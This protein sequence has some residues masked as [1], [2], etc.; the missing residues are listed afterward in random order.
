GYRIFQGLMFAHSRAREI[1]SRFARLPSPN[2]QSPAE[3]SDERHVF[4]HKCRGLQ[5]PDYSFGSR[6]MNDVEGC[7][8]NVRE[9]LPGRGLQERV[10]SDTH[11]TGSIA[12]ES[13]HHRN[14]T[15]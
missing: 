6:G 9:T 10:L 13:P 5:Q 4:N 11:L 15:L 14:G 3:F 8:F 12:A 7:N 2:V 1:L